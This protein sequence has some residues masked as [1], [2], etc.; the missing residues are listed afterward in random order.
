[1]RLPK[2]TIGVEEEYQ[3]VNPE[4]R[5][6]ASSA[7]EIMA[8]GR[9]LLAEQIKPEFLQSQV[10]VGSNICHDID[11][12]RA[13]FVRL[14]S[15]ICRLAESKGH[16]VAASGTHPISQ[17]AMQKVTAGERYTEH[18][19]N[20]ADVARRML[21]FG[22]HVHI[23][24]EDPDLRID[25]MNQARYFVPHFLALSTSSPFWEGRDTGLK[26]YRTL[27]MND[28]PRAGLPPHLNSFAEFESFVD[29]LVRTNCIDEP[30]KI[31]W[32]M[33]PHPKFPTIEFRFV[34]ICTKIDEAV[35]LAALFQALVGKLIRLRRSNISWRHYRRNL[36]TEN[37]WRAVR[38]GKDGVFIDLG[39]KI[40]LPFRTL[41]E[42]I[43]EF[44]D[45]VV[46]DLG[47]RRDVEYAQTIMEHGTSADR[48]LATYRKTGSLLAVVDQ[49]VAESREGCDL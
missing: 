33:R 36:I 35:C 43:L 15:A 17:W 45:D 13:E 39:R 46:D 21:V 23:G 20:M 18:E 37:K 6:L 19:K 14:R 41:M 42:E 31:W 8:E 1:M 9:E 4:T 30:T 32:D 11:E 16:C 22:M 7:D 28:L 24:I 38:H 3:I 48:Q 12:V 47:I 49:I 25:I 2:L 44:V 34:D 5:E 29:T 10:E 27:I 40:E 26:S